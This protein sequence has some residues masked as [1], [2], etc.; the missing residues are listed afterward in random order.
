MIQLSTA[1]LIDKILLSEVSGCFH[2]EFVMDALPDFAFEPGQFVSCVA[3]H[4]VTGKQQTR[5][6]SIASAAHGNT[7]ALC[8]NRV[9]AGLFSNMLCDLQVGETI[10]IYGPNGDFTLREPLTDS[11][12]IAT[13]T[14]VAPMRGF[15][16]RLFP[17]D[18][19]DSSQGKQFTLIYGT[20]HEAD[21][22]YRDYFE[23]LAAKHANFKY[24]PTLSRAPESWI[25]ERGY[26]QEHA[27]RLVTGLAPADHAQG[28]PF[29]IYAY[30]CGLSEMVHATRDRLRSLGWHRKQV[31]QERFN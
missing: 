26:V 28:P 3:A 17:K 21:I 9:E 30:I 19:P 1:R 20:R 7:F 2:L 23:Q 29:D 27:A 16:Q 8:V 4:P 14:G 12:F 11:I 25:G 6:Y 31:V 10:E 24:L 13:G 5:A 15:A 18:G 22:Y